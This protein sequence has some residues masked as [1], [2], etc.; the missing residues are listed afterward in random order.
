M[1]I[2]FFVATFIAA[3]G[4]MFFFCA[5]VDACVKEVSEDD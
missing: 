2:W 3:G 1:A 5:W 4:S